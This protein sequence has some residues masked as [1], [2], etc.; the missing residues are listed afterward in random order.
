MLSNLESIL[1]IE[2][3]RSKEYILMNKPFIYLDIINKEYFC[4]FFDKEYIYNYSLDAYNYWKKNE[5]VNAKQ[6]SLI[7]TLK[8]MYNTIMKIKN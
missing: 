2:R 7:S 6:E 1:R 3:L 5:I 4:N 8:M